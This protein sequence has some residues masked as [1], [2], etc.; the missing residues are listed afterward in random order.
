[1]E[2]KVYAYLFETAT[3]YLH[4]YQILHIFEE[5]CGKFIHHIIMHES[6]NTESRISLQI[7]D[8]V[9]KH[10]TIITRLCLII[11]ACAKIF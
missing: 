11:D 3:P 2:N 7:F 5:A 1:M 9:L 8:P 6:A 10:I 4:R